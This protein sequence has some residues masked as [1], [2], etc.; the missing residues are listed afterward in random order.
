[1]THRGESF[2]S[3]LRSLQIATAHYSDD[4]TIYHEKEAFNKAVVS[5]VSVGVGEHRLYGV[6]PK[7]HLPGE[8]MKGGSPAGCHLNPAGI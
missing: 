4:W 6:A 1:M 8:L 3:L 5:R 2:P 7:R